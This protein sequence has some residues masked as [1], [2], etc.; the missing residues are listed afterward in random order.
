MKI[1]DIKLPFSMYSKPKP[2]E[3]LDGTETIYN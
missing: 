1:T 3:K 2:I